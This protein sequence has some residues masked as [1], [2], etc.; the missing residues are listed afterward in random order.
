MQ[1]F[2]K[3]VVPVALTATALGTV[4]GYSLHKL[5]TEPLKT[6]AAAV[7]TNQ[8]S[9]AHE[10]K[11]GLSPAWQQQPSV[12]DSSWRHWPSLTDF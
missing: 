5:P 10:V 11:P 4:T 12:M 2:F 1:A 3:I 9:A 6:C 7:M 8:L